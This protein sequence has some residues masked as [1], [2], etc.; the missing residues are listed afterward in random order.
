MGNAG[1]RYFFDAGVGFLPQRTAS[2][3]W[4]RAGAGASLPFSSGASSMASINRAKI[5]ASSASSSSCED[6]FTVF[7]LVA[8]QR[9]AMTGG[10][11]TT[12]G[13]AL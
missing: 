1:S 5:S 8:N 7:G 4:L 9:A 12:L 3:V 10:G 11:V 13:S 2:F 6:V